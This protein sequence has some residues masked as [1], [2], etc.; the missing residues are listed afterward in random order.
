MTS[1]QTLCSSLLLF[2]EIYFRNCHKKN[3]LHHSNNDGIVRNLL[4]IYF[5]FFLVNMFIAIPEHHMSSGVHQTVGNCDI[6][7]TDLTGHKRQVRIWKLRNVSNERASMACEFKF[8]KQHI[9]S[10][11]KH[12][13]T[14]MRFFQHSAFGNSNNFFKFI[15][16]QPKICGE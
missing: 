14:V 12:F 2:F 1:F 16:M 7:D 9:H 13:L 3:L 6:Y 8:I 4:T 5:I 10:S 11:L 15:N